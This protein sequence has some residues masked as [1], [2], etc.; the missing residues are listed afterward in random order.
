M[1]FIKIANF[2][3]P[4]NTPPILSYSLKESSSLRIWGSIADF[5]SNS[6]HRIKIW[7]RPKARF[8]LLGW[9]VLKSWRTASKPFPRSTPFSIKSGLFRNRLARRPYK[10]VPLRFWSAVSELTTMGVSKFWRKTSK[11]ERNSASTAIRYCSTDHHQSRKLLNSASLSLGSKTPGFGSI[12]YQSSLPL[13]GR[14]A[15][16]VAAAAAASAACT[17]RN[18]IVAPSIWPAWLPVGLPPAPSMMNPWDS[19]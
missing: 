16:A 13:S 8:L 14:V 4:L 18:A 15:T 9:H 5:I 1:L 19:P 17:I 12:L 6:G 3:S 10:N 7:R 2:N 11:C